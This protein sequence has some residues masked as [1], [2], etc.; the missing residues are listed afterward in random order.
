MTTN[1]KSYLKVYSHYFN[2]H[3]SYSVSFN[4]GK[5]WRNFLWD[6]I[7]CYLSLEKKARIF[8]FC[9]PTP[10]SGLVKLGSFMSWW[11]NNG[12]EMN[13]I[14]WCTCKVV[15]CYYK[16]IMFCRSHCR[17]HRR[18]FCC[19]PEIAL[20][21]VTWRHTSLYWNNCMISRLND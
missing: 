4:F 19:H 2:L 5:S 3:R 20:P 9:S 18:W 15:V 8:V 6:Y 13:K 14:E 17:R 12:K 7:Y 10:Y 16:H 21:Y 1:R 11:C